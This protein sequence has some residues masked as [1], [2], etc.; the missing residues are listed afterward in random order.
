MVDNGWGDIVM[1]FLCTG[2]QMNWSIDFYLFGFFLRDFANRVQFYVY[3]CDS[4]WMRFTCVR[5]YWRV[6]KN[7]LWEFVTKFE[8]QRTRKIF[9]IFVQCLSGN[10]K[11]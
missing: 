5:I 4:Y 11:N 3:F 7:R 1:D 2:S 8:H 9:V 6:K 10:L